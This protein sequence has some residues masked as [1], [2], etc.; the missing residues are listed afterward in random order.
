MGQEKRINTKYT[1]K[2][3]GRSGEGGGNQ[4]QLLTPSN[5]N[6][7][8][9]HGLL[10]HVTY[11]KA[12]RGVDIMA[13]A[14]FPRPSPLSL[15][16]KRKDVKFYSRA[17]ILFTITMATS[18]IEEILTSNIEEILTSNIEE[19]LTSNIEEI[20]TSNIEEILLSVQSVYKKISIC[21]C[22]KLL[23]DRYVY[24]H[25]GKEIWV[26]CWNK[27]LYEISI[28]KLASSEIILTHK[29]LISNFISS[30]V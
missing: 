15:W 22:C 13:F 30:L 2:K 9:A 20:L 29:K 18:N 11:E 1:Y 12:R 16:S 19:I 26:P 17:N 5:R 27:I 10:F 8:Q 21:S 23:H 4:K 28:I 3:R 14:T 7:W 25:Q 6:G 24:S